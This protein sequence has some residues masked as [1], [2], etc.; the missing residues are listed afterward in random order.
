MCLI[1][2]ILNKAWLAWSA[3]QADSA[4]HPFG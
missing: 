3:N 1:L 4:F 2:P